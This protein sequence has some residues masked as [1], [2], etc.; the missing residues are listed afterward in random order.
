MAY[1]PPIAWKDQDTSTPL[2]A[3]NVKA[4][5][6]AL[7]GYTDTAAVPR[8]LV[9]AKGDLLVGTADNTV[10]RLG[11]GAAGHGSQLGI[12]ATTTSGLAWVRRPFINAGDP[13]FSLPTNGTTNAATALNNAGALCAVSGGGVVKVP[14]ATYTITSSLTHNFNA[15]VFWDFRG[16]KIILSGASVIGLDF[17]P[18]VLGDSGL[19][20]GMIGGHFVC[21]ASSQTGVRFRNANGFMLQDVRVEGGGV[22]IDFVND[23]AGKYNEKHHLKN[24]YCSSPTTGIRWRAINSGDP[25]MEGQL[26][27]NVWVGGFTT[28]YSVGDGVNMESVEMVN[29]MVQAAGVDSAT[30]ILTNGDLKGWRGTIIAEHLSGQNCVVWNADDGTTNENLC[31]ISL[32]CLPQTTGSN[33]PSTWAASP[34][35]KHA[36][37]ATPPITRDGNIFRMQGAVGGYTRKV[38]RDFEST[39]RMRE[40]YSGFEWGP[41]AGSALDTRWGRIAAGIVGT[42]GAIA[43]GNSA[44]A[45]SVGTVV[46]K[47]EVYD[48]N[49]NSLG[50]VPIVSS[51]S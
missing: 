21:G 43:V 4:M 30:C 14:P 49:G 51:S 5:E 13:Y 29:C 46:R 28:G 20:G 18:G 48:E 3:A 24:V 2:T 10:A 33:N 27:E 40:S 12:D 32:H 16:S 31:E 7:S 44:S 6:S 15:R 22:G 34:F 42:T 8:S 36:N 47:F 1:T 50:Y 35:I 9:D 26:F 38:R 37:V 45:S 41:G 17:N 11:I 19:G 23:G 25:S 39:D